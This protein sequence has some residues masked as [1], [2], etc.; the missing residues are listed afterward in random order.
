MCNYR[1]N[2]YLLNRYPI[3]E[4][5]IL[6]G[7]K[8][9]NFIRMELTKAQIKQCRVRRKWLK[10]EL[11]FRALQITNMLPVPAVRPR[12]HMHFFDNPQ[13]PRSS[14]CV[15]HQEVPPSWPPPI[16]RST[17]QPIPPFWMRA[18]ITSP[19]MKF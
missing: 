16:S 1:P 4:R 9:L 18:K 17:E 19:Y 10:G 6:H 2:G 3:L 15:P 12:V 13:L 11:Q 7:K 14:L 5:S 8:N